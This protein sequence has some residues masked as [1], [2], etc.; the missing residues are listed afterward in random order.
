[1]MHH[2]VVAGIALAFGLG[3]AL[4]TPTV[5]AAQ[6]TAAVTGVVLDSATR[7]PVSGVQVTVLGT[8]RGTLTDAS[9]RYALRGLTAGTVTLRAQRIGYS[10]VDRQRTLVAGQTISEDFTLR[11]VAGT[12]SEVLVVGYGTSTRRDVSSAITS[13]AVDEIVN[14]PVAGVD[15]AL[16]GR[17]PGVQV[18]QNAGNQGV[19]ITVRIR[20][21]A[22]IS[23]RNQPLYVVDGVPV[24]NDDFTQIGMGGQDITAVTGLNPDEIE[25]ITVLKDA[26]AAAIYGS[27]ASNGVIMIT[28]K[29][30]VV[31]VGRL[32]FSTYGGI[33]DVTRKV[34]VLT[35]PEYIEYFIEGMRNDGYSNTTILREL[36]TLDPT[37]VSNTDWQGAI[38]KDAMDAPVSNFN[39]GVSGGAERL[40][41]YLSGGFFDQRGVVLASGYTRAS[42]RL[43]VDFNPTDRLSFRTSVGVSREEHLRIENDN[44]IN[45]VVTNA[46]ALQPYIALRNSDGSYTSPDDGLEYTNPLAIADFNDNRVRSLRALG[47]VEGTYNLTNA[48]SLNARLGM[49]VVT[50]RELSWESPLVIG[51]YAQSANGVSW[52]G[53][54]TA[55]RYVMEGFLGWERG[56]GGNHVSL[57]GGSSVEYNHRELNTLIGEGFASAGVQFPG[58]AATITSYG[59]R[60]TGNNLVSFFSRANFTFL[61]RY[62]LTG[63]FRVDGSSRF[64]ANNRY[65]AFPA[66]SIGWNVSDEPFAAGLSRY[67]ALKL[68][69]SVGLTGNQEINDFEALSRFERANYVGEPGL[70]QASF[71]NP[72]LRWE[73][74]REV[75]LGF[76]LS[77][78]GGRLELIGDWYVKNTSDL[79]LSRPITST[80]GQT[81]VFENVGNM[82]NRG[83]ELGISTVNLQPVTEGG[84]GWN[85]NLNI[86]W[87]RN[88]VTRLFNDEPFNSGIRSVN[89]VEVGQPI[90]AYHLLR[91]DGVDPQTGD[92]IYFDANGDGTVNAD[93]RIIA[94]SA[95]PDYWGGFTNE[96][97]WGGFDLRAFLQFSQ[98]FEVYNAMAIFADDGGYYYDNKFSRVLRR[99]QQP[100]DITDQPRASWDGSSGARVVS[101]RY[102]EDGSYVR[103]Q[104]VTLG[105]R[106]P[107]QLGALAN[108]RDARIYL[109]GRNVHTWTD[110]QGYAPDVNSQGSSVNVSLGTDFYAYPIPRTIMFGI[111][112]SF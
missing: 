66:A 54:Q 79:L 65:G 21:S 84:F 58:N 16:Q 104:E 106:I 4:L 30:G 41:Y 9:G 111:A 67:G 82:E 6:E 14:T 90:G 81:S 51:T 38:F 112:G 88:R 11:P 102:I 36:G 2:M 77:M 44:T 22:S 74:T 73:S 62:L 59:A 8:Q 60:P 80:S 3:G 18:V 49:D 29:R 31:G 68:R 76:D 89:R 97:R 33:Q 26:A 37:S 57:T 92:A 56:F 109:S 47:S 46:I 94:G 52:F 61:D 42:G 27:R 70:A 48:L 85:T 17:A 71:G 53:G 103:L 78:I 23:A 69:A 93:D 83:F 20:G 75:N 101:S 28:T 5:A 32:T 95:H 39:I 40:R 1:M 87:N 25:S 19:G 64:G 43:N 108:L 63:S 10:A 98:G 105:Y 45:G 110:Y 107:A 13:V 99:W 96:L 12:L 72:D 50:L 15:A 91:F 86:T 35:G 55:N 34:P 7:Q 100:G 24:F